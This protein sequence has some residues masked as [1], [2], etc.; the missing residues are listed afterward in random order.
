MVK[1]LQEF[2]GMVNF[3]HRFIPVASGIMRPLF[4]HTKG[5]ATDKLQWGEEMTKAFEKAKE[6]LAK[7]TLLHHNL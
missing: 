1:G 7:T 2:V 3:Y 5:K 4:A 6:A